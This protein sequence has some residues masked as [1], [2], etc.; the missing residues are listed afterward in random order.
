MRLVRACPLFVAAALT[1]APRASFAADPAAARE[2]LKIGFTLSQ[3]GKCAEAIPHLAESIRLDAKAIALLNLANCEELTGHLADAMGHWVDAR[4][5]AQTEGAKS[6]EDEAGRRLS[7]LEPRLPR[8]TIAL[9]PNAPKDAVVELH[10]VALAASLNIPL[11]IDP[12]SHVIVVKAKGRADGSTQVT[13][14]EGETKRVEV[15]AGEPS[16]A[17]VVAVE[18]PTLPSE[19]GAPRSTSSGVS[20]LV[21]IGL[22]VAAAGVGVGSVTG[23]M[24]AGAASDAKVDCPG[25]QCISDQARQDAESGQTLGTIST[26][27][28]IVGAAGA[29]LAVYGLVWGNKKQDTTAA[30]VSLVP[31]GATLRG[32]F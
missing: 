18:K 17:N 27:A 25:G 16:V 21:W 30:T 10:G 2:Q 19:P 14:A 28:F 32:W 9:A 13:L 5:R 24:A 8:L 15:N 1:V 3:E 12:G 20:P 31:G 4:T 6:I 26:V 11:P 29:G 7:A 22:G 23:I